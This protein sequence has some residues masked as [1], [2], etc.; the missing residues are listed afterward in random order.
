AVDV[1]IVAIA[2]VAAVA[3]KTDWSVAVHRAQAVALTSLLAPI[4]IAVFWRMGIYRQTW[5]L[6]GIDEFSRACASA[7]VV[8]VVAMAARSVLMMR[9]VSVS[10]LASFAMIHVLLLM[11]CRASYQILAA[12]RWRIG[13]RGTPVLIYGAGRHGVTALCELAAS[14]GGPLRP[15]AFIDD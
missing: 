9:D 14:D 13:Q 6:A 15:V 2:A 11:G 1:A 7:I 3:V 5:R 4:T 12:S 8:V 10:L